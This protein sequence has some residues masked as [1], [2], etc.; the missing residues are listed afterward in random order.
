VFRPFFT[1]TVGISRCD[2]RIYGYSPP[3]YRLKLWAQMFFWD[4][5]T[6]CYE[7]T[8]SPWN[9]LVTKHLGEILILGGKNTKKSRCIPWPPRSPNLTLMD[10]SFWGFVED[11]VYIPPMPVDLQELRDRIVNATVLLHVTF[12]GKLWVELEYRLDVCRISRVQYWTLVKG[13]KCYE[14]LYNEFSNLYTLFCHYCSRPNHGRCDYNY[15]NINLIH[16]TIWLLVK[17]L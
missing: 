4:R 16:P 7:R 17:I 10:F 15:L 3:N 1:W 11:N 9:S 8:C 14:M 12:L 2:I 5:F 13:V 6:S